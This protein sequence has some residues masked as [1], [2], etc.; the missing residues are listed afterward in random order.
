MS[1]F[2]FDS[3]DGGRLVVNH[4]FASLLRRHQWT[5]FAAIWSQTAEAAVAKKLR[6]DRITLRFTLDDRG[7]ERAFYIKRH[8]QSSWKE[9]VKPMLRLR[10]P[11]LGAKPEWR[12]LLH[13][14]EADLPTMTPVALGQCGA[15]SFLIT[16]ALENCTKLSELRF[17]D[18]EP[19]PRAAA[20]LE[21][22][23]TS[24]LPHHRRRGLIGTIARLTKRMHAA[25]LHHQDLYLGHLLLRNDDTANDQVYV[26]DLGRVQKHQRL[27]SHWIVKDLAQLNYSARDYSA[28]DRLRFLRGYLGR[29]LSPADKRLV[30]K[31]VGKSSA[32]SRHSQKNSL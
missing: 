13:F 24:S 12:A 11:I 8:G 31:I 18:A 9:Y 30:A 21:D 5:T 17:D 2:Q 7:L 28:V 16:E 22:A 25:G 27:T 4:D 26:I 23:S 15:N 29:K 6:T 1:H 14:H 32:I 3:F 19:L 20:C 10:L